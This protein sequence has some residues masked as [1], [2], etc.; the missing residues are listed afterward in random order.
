MTI[1]SYDGSLISYSFIRK[2]TAV[3]RPNFLAYISYNFGILDPDLN[4]LS[5]LIFTP[6]HDFV[7]E[8]GILFESRTV[9][10]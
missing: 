4:D 8:L 6:V 9:T 10:I 3:G 7:C 1:K 2:R 5:D